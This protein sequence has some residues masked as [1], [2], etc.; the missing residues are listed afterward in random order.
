[1]L[2][3]PRCSFLVMVILCLVSVR[4][5]VTPSHGG[6]SF[7]LSVVEQYVVDFQSFELVLP[8]ELKRFW[9]I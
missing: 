9:A 5:T 7:V 1:M 3:F 2:G 6:A 8:N 4:G